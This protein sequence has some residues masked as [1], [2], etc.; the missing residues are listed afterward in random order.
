M[1]NARRFQLFGQYFRFFHGNRTNK[2]GLSL[3]VA[4]FYLLDYRPFLACHGGKYHI[5]VVYSDHRLI[6]GHLYAV[7]IIYFAELVL[8]GKRRTGHTG[9]L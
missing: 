2:H 1:G 9:Q 5:A 7:K 6:G 8:L 4:F 3:F